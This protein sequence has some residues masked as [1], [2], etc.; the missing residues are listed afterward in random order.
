MA[1]VGLKTAEAVSVL[2]VFVAISQKLPKY[3]CVYAWAA[4]AYKALTRLFFRYFSI[5]K[6][7]KLS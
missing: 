7:K 5:D 4:I 3:S 2:T 1:F 6:D